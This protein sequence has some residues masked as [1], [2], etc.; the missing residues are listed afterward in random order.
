MFDQESYDKASTVTVE[1]QPGELF[2]SYEIKPWIYS[3][4]LYKIVAASFILNVAALALVSQTNMLTARGCDSPWVGRVCQVVDMAYVG[5]MLFGS[6]REYVDEVYEKTDLGEAEITY[7][8]VTGETPPLSYPEGYFQIANPVQFA[9]LQQQAA[10]GVSGFNSVAMPGVNS[11]FSTPPNN[12]RDLLRQRPNPPAPKPDALTD[13]SKDS[14]LF[15]VEDSPKSEGFPSRKR[16]GGGKVDFP[17]SS[18]DETKAPGKDVS[19][20]VNSNKTQTDIKTDPITGDEINN[21]PFKDLG[22][23]VNEALDKKETNLQS[24]FL[25]SAKGKLTKE[26]KL[27][28]KSFQYIKADSVDKKLIEVVQEAIEAFNDSGRL[29]VLRN[30]S[31]DDLNLEVKQDAANVSAVVQSEV[32]SE[33]RARSLMSS[34]SLLLAGAKKFK[35][36]EDAS[37]ND[38]D[39]LLLLEGAKIEQ[40][41]KNLIIRF[42]VPKEVVHQMIQR[43]LAEAKKQQAEPTSTASLSAKGTTASK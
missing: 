29:K 2:H 7:V 41:G 32:E 9:M 5:A 8:D 36:G 33:S 35:S 3:P 42:N 21:R 30:L 18:K 11:G 39:D 15:K 19:A 13:D 27:D 23:F 4:T 24:E 20:E 17:P 10:N 40:D 12:D 1:S 34:L 22:K 25:L 26:G 31:G 14:A 43:K 6:E 38:K 16:L 28:P 37:P